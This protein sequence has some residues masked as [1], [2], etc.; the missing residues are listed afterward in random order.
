MFLNSTLITGIDRFPRRLRDWPG[1]KGI[2]DNLRARMAFTVREYPALGVNSVSPCGSRP[3]GAAIAS[4]VPA[5]SA[6][7]PNIRSMRKTMVLS[8][9]A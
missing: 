2:P 4:V 1:A 5:V 7:T 8:F 3:G 6:V 9:T